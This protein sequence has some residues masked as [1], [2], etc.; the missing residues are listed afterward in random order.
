MAHA[1]SVDAAGPAGPF[2]GDRSRRMLWIAVAV[3]SVLVV[4][5]LAV[6]PVRQYL[7]QR[8]QSAARTQTLTQ[9]RKENERLQ[10]RVDA[11]NTPAEIQRIAREEY[12]L[13]FPGE[14][15]YAVLPPKQSGPSLPAA[16]P[17]GD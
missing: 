3:L 6:F 8:S 13:V 1:A 15:T 4:L 2:L 5:S 9:L 11:L 10:A 17:F 14:E 7:D 16:W 12:S